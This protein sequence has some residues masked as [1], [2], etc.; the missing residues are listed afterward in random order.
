MKEE[1]DYRQPPA[2]H[3]S[4]SVQSLCGIIEPAATTSSGQIVS[5]L[6]SPTSSVSFLV[7]A[8]NKTFREFLL[9]ALPMLIHPVII[10]RLLAHKLFGNMVKRKNLPSDCK[11]KPPK[12]LPMEICPP[13]DSL[14]E[15]TAGSNA[16]G[17]I[18]GGGVGTGV[19]VGG[20]GGIP[21]SGV[22][23]GSSGAGGGI[24]GGSAGGGGGGGSVEN[25]GGDGG[26]ESLPK[27]RKINLHVQ[28]TNSPEENNIANNSLKACERDLSRPNTLQIKNGT[29]KSALRVISESLVTPLDLN[30]TASPCSLDS[31]QGT[32]EG[33]SARSTRKLF[34][35]S[36]KKRLSKSNVNVSTLHRDSVC[37][38]VSQISSK[39]SPVSSSQD[40]LAFQRELINLPTFELDTTMY[41]ISP[42][43]S[44]SSS[45]PE[46]LSSR[47]TSSSSVEDTLHSITMENFASDNTLCN[48][49]QV[50]PQTPDSLCKS[51]SAVTI[52]AT[53]METNL[54]NNT[55]D[56]FANTSLTNIVVR[57]E[58][59]SSPLGSNSSQSPQTFCDFFSSTTPAS[60]KDDSLIMPSQSL[61][62]SSVAVVERFIG[63]TSNSPESDVMPVFMNANGVSQVTSPLANMLS[64]IPYD[65][66]GVLKVMDTWVSVCK[67]DLENSSLVIHEMRDFLNKLS[68]LGHEY[69]AWCHQ[70][71]A[72]L[73]LEVSALTQIFI[74]RLYLLHELL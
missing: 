13:R 49:G 58:P 60:S 68:V 56:E 74:F 16:A 20:G 40:I 41:D 38:Q 19:V 6:I 66:R 69:K 46:N 5:P 62:D 39:A 73:Q 72:L 25:N 47:V 28:I 54:I 8:G 21:G 52:R 15:G 57:F 36:S 1:S 59:P 18:D 9:S 50:A 33:E 22:G 4:S 34:R 42:V 53:N 61:T 27:R 11:L 2:I 3:L 32:P 14:R 43:F 44:R 55:D 65:H 30:I 35:W 67:S 48:K 7:E 64:D 29:T 51:N 45:V 37:S 10:L 71:S 23:G 70:I 31:N 24:G 17:G 63:Q 12:V 26:K